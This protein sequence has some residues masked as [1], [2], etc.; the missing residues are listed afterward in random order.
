MSQQD[1][2]SGQR[3]TGSVDAA[4]PIALLQAM[5]AHDRPGEFL[6]DEDLTIS[7]PRRLGL[8][9]VVGT[10]IMRYEAAERA[11]RSVRLDEFIGLV[12]LVLRRPDAEPVLRETGQRIARW[13]FRRTPDLW[14]TLLH[15]APMALAVRSGRRASVRALRALH[16][17][18]RVSGA[19]P[20][21]IRVDNCITAAIPESGTACVMFTALLE[22]VLLLYTG[23]PAHVQHTSCGGEEPGAACQW[24]AGV[25][26]RPTPSPTL[27][28][29]ATSP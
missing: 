4:V 25:N 1:T 14:Q 6:E 5:R 20:F 18:T 23:R 11:N 12:R 15:R 13:Q 26:P 29:S 17:G 28:S 8:T 9:G 16:A 19:K 24:T 3:L 2:T 27:P 21:E 10:Q 22:E 7:L